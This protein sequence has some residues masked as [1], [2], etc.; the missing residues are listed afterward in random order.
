MPNPICP[1]HSQNFYSDCAIVP[2][3]TTRKHCNISIILCHVHDTVTVMIALYWTPWCSLKALLS[4]N[5]EQVYQPAERQAPRYSLLFS[6]ERPACLR[7]WEYCQSKQSSIFICTD[8]K[9]RT[10]AQHP[11]RYTYTVHTLTAAVAHRPYRLQPTVH[12]ARS[13]S[14]APSKRAAAAAS[15][16]PQHSSA[17]NQTSEPRSET[18]GAG[19]Q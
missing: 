14:H 15:A 3:M 2:Y 10:N 17:V 12:S 7:L 1:P 6:Y 18:Q 8:D 4:M 19:F 13:H 5:I 11:L 16:P 9:L